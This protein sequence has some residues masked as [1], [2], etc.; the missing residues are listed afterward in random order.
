M[1]S[2]TPPTHGASKLRSSWCSE[3]H[4]ID[5]IFRTTSFF[6]Q[7]VLNKSD[8]EE[9][10]QQ[11]K[12]R[13]MLCGFHFDPFSISCVSGRRQSFNSQH[14][15][16]QSFSHRFR[17]CVQSRSNDWRE[18]R[19]PQQRRNKCWGQYHQ[20]SHRLGRYTPTLTPI[21]DACGAWSLNKSETARSPPSRVRGICQHLNVWT[22]KQPRAC[23]RTLNIYHAYTQLHRSPV[24]HN[25]SV[26]VSKNTGVFLGKKFFLMS[27]HS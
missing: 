2:G 19:R 11:L 22:R 20:F 15:S 4:H 25:S 17:C 1:L 3:G 10:T 26:C 6:S 23:M 12:Q 18:H 5:S 8:F 21:L 13:F 16:Q 9:R 7:R 27:S 14:S 24:S